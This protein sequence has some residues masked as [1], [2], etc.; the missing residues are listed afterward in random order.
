MSKVQQAALLLAVVGIYS[1]TQGRKGADVAS[2]LQTWLP[3]AG[4]AYFAFVA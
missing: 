2:I 1:F 4:A 3:I